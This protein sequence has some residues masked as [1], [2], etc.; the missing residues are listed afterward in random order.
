MIVSFITVYQLSKK[1]KFSRFDSLWLAMFF[2]FST[3]LFSSSVMNISAYQVQSL[4][5]P[6]VL[7]ALYAYFSGKKS[8]LAGI[9]IGLAIMTRFTLV[10]AVVFFLFEFLKK[11]LTVKQLA[12]LMV[13]VIVC[14]ILLALYNQRR[15]HSFFE[16]GYSYNRI[17]GAYPL[18]EN[19]KHGASSVTHMPAHIYSLFIMPPE[20]LRE[21]KDGFFL[22]FPYLIANPWGMAIWY[23]SPLFLLLLFRFKKN[24]YTLSV[25]AACGAIIVPLITYY[26]IGFVQ[27]GYRYAL[28]FLPFLFLLLLPSLGPKLS[29]TAIAL[30]TVGVL[31]NLIYADSV[32]GIYPLLNLY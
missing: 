14:C 20:P 22:K 8:F 12:R 10:L 28:D 24:K 9:L 26:S 1:F 6:L 11:R 2:V 16:M 17:K 30:I 19:L 21:Q 13:P 27:F 32:F 15:F 23:T 25:A 5:V 3:V 31:F 29:K 7:L 18:S 4:G